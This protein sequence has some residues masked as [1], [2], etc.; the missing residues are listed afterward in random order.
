MVMKSK[1]IKSSNN[2]KTLLVIL[3]ILTSLF[4]MMTIYPFLNVFAIAFSSN[5]E[6][7]KNPFMIFPA[8][9]NLDSFFRVF[10]DS[11]IIMGYK[12]TIIVTL[13]AVAIGVSITILTAYPLSKKELPGR[14]IFMNLIIFTMMFSGGMIPNFLVIKALGLYDTLWALIL[15]GVLTGFNIILMKN[16]FENFP[17]SLEEAARID[18]ASDVYVLFRI[19][20]PL[21]M[22]IIATM[23]LFIGVGFWNSYFSAIIYTRSPDK[24]TLQL[25]LR[26]IIYSSQNIYAA[27]G[28]DSLE[29]GQSIV[30]PI[31]VQYAS[32]IAAVLPIM[33]IYPFLQKYFT[34][35]V[36]IG[37]VKG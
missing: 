11:S 28:G 30:S 14:T 31:T 3:Y 15:P 33:C 36:M 17:A 19:V 9:F 27:T 1:V 25:V 34:K 18:G 2:D 35:G 16:F 8:G 6:Y 37:A 7:I 5:T 21:S 22:P 23:V 29:S 10:Q 26:E 24:W 4:A 13:A 32:L 20:V 12:N